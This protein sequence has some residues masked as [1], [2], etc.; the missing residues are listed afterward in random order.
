MAQKHRNYLYFNK[1]DS[2]ITVP[3]MTGY[4]R[5]FNWAPPRPGS[6]CWW[7]WGFCLLVVFFRGR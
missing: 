5:A 4:G 2:N 7:S 3:K 6:S 1:D